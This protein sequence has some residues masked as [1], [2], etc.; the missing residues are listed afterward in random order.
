VG[1]K[2]H[3]AKAGDMWRIRERVAEPAGSTNRVG[4]ASQARG[5]GVVGGG[6]IGGRTDVSLGCEGVPVAPL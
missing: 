3:V 2:A 1:E 6:L 4:E 5:L